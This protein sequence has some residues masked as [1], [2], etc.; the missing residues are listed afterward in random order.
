MAEIF[1]PGASI[2]QH[3]A[4]LVSG[5]LRTTAER[6]AAVEGVTPA[7]L[8]RAGARFALDTGYLL[9]PEGQEVGAAL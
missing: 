5:H 6:I 2:G 3:F 4:E 7:D 8:Q 9:A 1:T